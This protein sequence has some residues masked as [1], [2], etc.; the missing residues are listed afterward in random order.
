MQRI[1]LELACYIRIARIEIDIREVHR[2]KTAVAIDEN[3]VDP[4]LLDACI[5]LTQINVVNV[6]ARCDR[7]T[8]NSTFEARA[9]S[10]THLTL[11]TMAV[12]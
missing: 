10:Y 3:V 12:V 8:R 4:M 7:D 5:M 1:N 11:P 9:V 2:G 6:T